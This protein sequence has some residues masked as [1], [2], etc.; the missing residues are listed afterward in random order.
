MRLIDGPEPYSTWRHVVSNST[1]TVIG[2]AADSTN[3]F[4][5]REVVVYVS[6]HYQGLRVRELNEFMDGRFVRVPSKE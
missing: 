2:V 1:Y 6:H 4:E 5:P 3:G